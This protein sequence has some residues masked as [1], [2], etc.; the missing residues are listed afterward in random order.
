[1]VAV[2]YLVVTALFKALYAM[3]DRLLFSFR[4]VGR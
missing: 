1:V 4:Y 3:I 2:I